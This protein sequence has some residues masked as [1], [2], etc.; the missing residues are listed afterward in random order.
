MT[1]LVVESSQTELAAIASIIG[2][3]YPKAQ[4][5]PFDDGME[6]VQYGFNHQIDVVYS[7]V[8]LPHLTGFDIARLLRRVHPDIKVY[9]L[10]NSTQYQKRAEKEGLSGFHCLPLTKAAIREAD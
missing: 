6:A 3:A 5:H 8:I 1:I 10:D 7:A 2:S 9:L 4:I